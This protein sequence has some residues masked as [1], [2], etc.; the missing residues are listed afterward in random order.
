MV[1]GFGGINF[2]LSEFDVREIM[3][4]VFAD[5]PLNGKRVLV[6]VPD[7]TRTAPMSIFFKHFV[8]LLEPRVDALGFLI[9]LGTHPAM[10]EE[11]INKHLG[12][13]YKKYARRNKSISIFNHIWN[14]PELLKP[15]GRIEREDIQMLTGG[16][17]TDGLS[18]SINQKIF[19]YDLI[20]VC[21]PVFPHEIV[22]FSGGDK[23]FF[24]GISGPEMIN[25]THWLGALLTSMEI[26]GKPNTTVRVLIE[27]AVSFIPIP[28]LYFN[29]IVGEDGLAG[30]FA[31]DSKESWLK[32][33]E[34]SSDLNILYTDRKYNK[35]LSVMPEIYDDLWTAAKG[36]YKVEPVVS[37]GGE[38][39]I[40][41]PHIKEISYTHGRQIDEIG[42]HVKDYFV[43]Q[44]DAFKHFPWSVLGHSTHLRGSGE[45]DIFTAKEN[46][47]IRVTLATGIPKDRC[48]RVNLGYMDPKNIHISDFENQEEEGVLVVHRAGEILYRL[49]GDLNKSISR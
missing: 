13:E 21:G 41:A 12:I 34:I 35:V 14:S 4:N 30:L 33:V 23:Y 42:Y 1:Y 28:H 39:I 27:K 44:W 45:Y 40:F 31:G 32:A 36:M 25:Y 19:E 6:I 43:D 20:I 37:N 15:I 8:Q 46:P 3:E 7:S 16:L 22:G 17:L 2:R 29:M 18:I 5:I 9:A 11:K 24:P 47:R 10:S 26:I 38:V 48:E 49:S